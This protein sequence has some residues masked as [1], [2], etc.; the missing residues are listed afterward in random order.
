MSPDRDANGGLGAGPLFPMN[1][2]CI[3][4]PLALFWALSLTAQY[5]GPES[6]EY[7]PLGDRYLVSN[8][9]T[10]IIRVRDQAGQVSDFSAVLPNAPYGLELLGDVL[11]AC[12]GNGIRGFDRTTGQ[13]VYQRDLG[14]LFPNGITTDGTFLYV[15]DFSGNARRIYKVDPAADTHTTLVANTGGQPNGIVWDPQGQRLVTVFWGGNAPI[16]A[17]DRD[18]GAETVLLANSGLGNNDGITIDCNWDFLISSWSPQRLTR[19]EPTFTQPGQNMNVSGLA[20]P[21]DIDFDPV[22]RVVCIPNSSANSVVLWDI[23]TDCLTTAIHR[24]EG[25]E[26]RA[27]PNPTDGR[28][29]LDPPLVRQESY[30]LLDARGLLVGGGSLRP[31]AEM[32]LTELPAGLYTIVLTSDGRRLVVVRE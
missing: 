8:T 29:R 14:A 7:D 17:Y 6:V 16:K 9:S 10:R 2:S 18:T 4:L 19:F 3:L 5:S 22:N 15:T 13:Q 20:N 32:D 27:I 25:K 28:I 30:V 24:L 31:G 1:R 12:S 11:Y 23:A 26:L 21:A